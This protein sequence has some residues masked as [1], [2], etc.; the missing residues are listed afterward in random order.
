MMSG[1]SSSRVVAAVGGVVGALLHAAA[2]AY[3]RQ[4]LTLIHVAYK[5]ARHGESFTPQHC[6]SVRSAPM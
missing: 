4:P 2:M 6:N 3:A 1:G 5:H